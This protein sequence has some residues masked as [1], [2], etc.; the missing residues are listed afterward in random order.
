MGI[1]GNKNSVQY[2]KNFKKQI[3]KFM[4]LEFRSKLIESKY[5]I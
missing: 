2:R 4:N 3:L 5:L 1:V